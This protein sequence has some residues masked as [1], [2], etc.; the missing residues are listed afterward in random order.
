MMIQ[1]HMSSMIQQST[2]KKHAAW[3]MANFAEATDI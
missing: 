2:G 3:R 1:L